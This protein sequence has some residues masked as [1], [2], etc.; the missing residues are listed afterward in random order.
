[1]SASW[2]RQSTHHCPLTTTM[3]SS[4]KAAAVQEGSSSQS[5]Q[6]VRSL[7]PCSRAAVGR[8]S[9]CAVG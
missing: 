4:T 3:S 1:M 5:A 7:Q 9:I 6:L 2:Q 8:W